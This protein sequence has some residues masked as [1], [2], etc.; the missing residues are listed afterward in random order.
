MASQKHIFPFANRCFKINPHKFVRAFN[1]SICAVGVPLEPGLWQMAL[2]R[3][4]AHLNFFLFFC[5]L[6]PPTSACETDLQQP[7]P[8]IFLR[9]NWCNDPSWACT[10]TS[11]SALVACCGGLLHLVV[12]DMI[13]P[14]LF[15]GFT[16]D[17]WDLVISL[18]CTWGCFVR[19]RSEG[20]SPP[21]LG[22]ATGLSGRRNP[23]PVH[24]KNEHKCWRL[25]IYMRKHG[26]SGLEAF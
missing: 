17:N 22:T 9:G 18:P 4:D 20:Q 10:R 1:K 25:L 23:P 19:C 13:P 7:S 21:P 8:G 11:S 16:L 2:C 14:V 26:Q 12:R 6:L 3:V 15:L 5:S 24:C